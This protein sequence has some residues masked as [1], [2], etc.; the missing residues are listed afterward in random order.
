MVS[1]FEVWPEAVTEIDAVPGAIGNDPVAG[2]RSNVI[3]VS[4][5]LT[6]VTLAPS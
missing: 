2:G 1:L 6:I 4:L 5:Q 3:E